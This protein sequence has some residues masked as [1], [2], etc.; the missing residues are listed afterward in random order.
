[1]SRAAATKKAYQ[2]L[3]KGDKTIGPRK[4]KKGVQPPEEEMSATKY[5]FDKV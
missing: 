1:M 2:E 4:Q 3:S 5:G